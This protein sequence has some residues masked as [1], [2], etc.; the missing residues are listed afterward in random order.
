MIQASELRIGNKVIYNNIVY[1]V[2]GIVLTDV[3]N[4]S[5]QYSITLV[6]PHQPTINVDS[7]L[8]EPISLTEEILLKY[9]STKHHDEKTGYDYMH[10][11]VQGSSFRDSSHIRFDINDDGTIVWNGWIWNEN[12]IH[13][14]VPNEVKY[15]HQLQNLYFALT[16]KE[17]EIQI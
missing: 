15:L 6:N 9:G 13:F 1:Q 4:T 8:I 2:L 3:K 5:Y 16:G 7:E 10:L 12:Q 14:F 17:L 11:H